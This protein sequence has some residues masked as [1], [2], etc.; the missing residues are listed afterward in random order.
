MRCG[1]RRRSSRKLARRRLVVGQAV[2]EEFFLD[3]LTLDDVNDMFSR[4]VGNQLPTHVAP[5][6]TEDRKQHCFVCETGHVMWIKFSFKRI[7]AL[8]SSDF[9]ME[10]LIKTTIN[11]GDSACALSRNTKPPD[12]ESAVLLLW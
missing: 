2:Q 12:R 9:C 3:C 4:N 8:L 1:W 6:R 5:Q 7:K 11:S 10:K